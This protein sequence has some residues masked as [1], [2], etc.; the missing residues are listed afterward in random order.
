V[1]KTYE[2]ILFDADDTLFHFDAWTGLQRMFAV[3]GIE[4]TSDDHEAYEAINQPLWKDYQNGTINAEQLQNQ[5][6]SGWAVKLGVSAQELN[7]AFMH[8][9]AEICTTM[10]GAIHL[11]GA[12]RGKVKL[13]IITNGFTQLMQARLERTGLAGHFDLLVISEQAGMAKPQKGIFD[14]A[15]AMIG[16]PARHKVLMVGDNPESDILGGIN[17]GI[18]T[19]WLNTH[20]KP[21]PE[22]IVP[23][24][25]VRSL[26][27]LQHLLLGEKQLV[28]SLS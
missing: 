25:Q 28:G 8:S 17:A 2:W 4:F 7:M 22:G 9:M 5:R 16:N 15:L 6:F 11:L 19:C 26:F 14:H 18:D 10:D 13:G 27:E 1:V 24:Y 21:L 12:L 23:V 3:Y 20:N